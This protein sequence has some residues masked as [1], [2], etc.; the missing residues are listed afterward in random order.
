MSQAARRRD[1]SVDAYAAGF[2]D[3]GVWGKRKA[4]VGN[5]IGVGFN[6]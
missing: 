6:G 4:K 2:Y 5:Y 3:S 1:A